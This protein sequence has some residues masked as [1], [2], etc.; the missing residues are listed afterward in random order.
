M[1]TAEDK[2]SHFIENET[3]FHL[4]ELLTEQSHQKTRG[5]S[6]TI[7]SST[8]DGVRMLREVDDELPPIADKVF[9]GKEFSRLV[10]SI[11]GCLAGNRRIFLSGCGATGRLCIL[12]ET[13]WRRFWKNGKS[14]H[15]DSFRRISDREGNVFS[16]MSA[17][18]HALIRSVEG[19]EDYAEFG[20]RQIMEAGVGAGDVVVA[21]SE[22]GETSS[23][24]GTARH[25]LDV[26]AEVFFV[27]NNPSEILS[28]RVKRSRELINDKRVTVLDLASGPMA[29]AGSTRMQATTMELLAVG[30]ALELGLERYLQD[31]IGSKELDLLSFN[32]MDTVAY[33][34]HFSGILNSLRSPE[35]I[36]AAAGMIEFEESV[37]HQKGLVTYFAD[38]YQLDIL[39]DTTE[40]APTFRLPPFRKCDDRISP[41]SW[42]FVKN[43]IHPTTEAWERLLHRPPRGLDWT[44]ETFR[45]MGASQEFLKQSPNLCVSEILKYQIGNEDDV[46]RHYPESNAAILVMA[47]EEDPSGSSPL[48][49]GFTKHSAKYRKKAGL[50]IGMDK[51]PSDF[52]GISFTIPCRLPKSPLDIWTRLAVKMLLNTVST[53]TCA[54]LGRVQ[55]NWM[56]F[57]ETSNKKLI[58]RASRLI[59]ELAQVPYEKAC[60][61]LFESLEQIERNRKPGEIPP[62]PVQVSLERI[63]H[64]QAKSKT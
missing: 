61:A 9:H 54:R 53:G 15:P 51:A 64:R 20:S 10:S 46:F 5:F 23:V 37:Y 18:D 31:T 27:F 52:I 45:E 48:L 60:L 21:I 16:I 24:I 12:L 4:G 44:K 62:S 28:R 59:S 2:A 55:G 57:V 17:G 30:T 43:P 13:V 40:R 56:A 6:T 1:Q 63:R 34:R 25:G 35:A 33:S 7:I 39:T 47:G 32:D 58:D 14:L 38:E 22:G 42:A 36:T 49:S 8:A 41:P 26:G 29:I 3:E 50:F 11:H 19:F